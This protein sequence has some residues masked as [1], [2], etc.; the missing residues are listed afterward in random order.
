[1]GEQTGGNL[2]I[3]IVGAGVAGLATASRLVARSG[4]RVEVDL[5]DRNLTPFGLLRNGVAPDH[6][7]RGLIAEFEETLRQPGV[8]FLGGVEVGRD[9]TRADL[10]AAYDA[11]VYA[12][13]APADRLLDVPGEDLPGVSSGRAFAQWYS[14]GEDAVPFD[15]TGVAQVVIVGLGDVAVDLARVLLKSPASFA[16]TDM[17]EGVRRHLEGHRV[18]D[19]TV[20][21]RRG[22]EACRLKPRDLGELLSLPGVAVRFDHTALDVDVSALP[23]RVQ[24]AFVL[25]R[26]A[27]LREVQ[28][29]RTKLR[30]KFWT[31]PLEFRGAGRVDGV[32]IEKTM[33]DK[34]GRLVSGG[35]PD[36]I[37]AQLVLRA[38][39]SRGVPL[40]DVPFDQ[41][42]GLIP[43]DDHRVV[44]LTGAVQPGEYAA[45]WIAIGWT[46]GFGA[47]RRN[48]DAVAARL[49]ADLVREPGSVDRLLAER[50]IRPVGFDGW[51]RVAA[52]ERAL[53]AEHGR[54]RERI[55]DPETLARL[56][57]GE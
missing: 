23:E 20:L 9:L 16:E 41:R 12:T 5:F 49:L 1:M 34:A 33:L 31:R 35:K 53:G 14:G 29:A 25:W 8:R 3:G 50:G 7:Y 54:V 18:R 56:A 32:R 46:S 27:T 39:G 15:L 30:I 40:P 26:A 24:E 4:H 19:I 42:T 43:T 44:D 37:P 22:P 11:V 51:Q 48:A 13:G 28:G 21:V 45:G 2:R 57:H 52:A 6:D 38:T 17:P 55:T 36:M 47:Q 10:L